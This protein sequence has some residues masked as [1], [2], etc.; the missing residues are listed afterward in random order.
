MV[1]WLDSCFLILISIYK[2]F[3]LN[4]CEYFCKFLH[5]LL[6]SQ[7][8][9]IS[10]IKLVPKPIWL[11]SVLDRD[12]SKKI[13]TKIAQAVKLKNIRSFKGVYP[14]EIFLIFGLSSLP[15]VRSSDLQLFQILL[16]LSAPN[17]I[18]DSFPFFFNMF[19]FCVWW[20]EFWS[21]LIC[22]FVIKKLFRLII[23]LRKKKRKLIL[24]CKLHL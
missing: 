3:I 15:M 19:S 13:T 24:D 12:C 8:R 22:C 18:Y 11:K 14:L 2:T 9:T 10:K 17:S 16:C 6:C 20:I 21:F 4:S 7:V 1:L 23:F 5:S